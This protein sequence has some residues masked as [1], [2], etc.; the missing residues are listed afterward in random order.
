LVSALAANKVAVSAGVWKICG[1]GAYGRPYSRRRAGS[2]RTVL[3]QSAQRWAGSMRA[4]DEDSPGVRVR[5]QRLR[6]PTGPMQGPDQLEPELLAQR[7]LG[8]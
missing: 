7:V 2:A 5:L 8:H 6:P 4:H 1:G 3:L